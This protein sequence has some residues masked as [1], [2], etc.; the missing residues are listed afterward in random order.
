MDLIP[1]SRRSPRE[2]N[3]NLL[4]YSCWEIPWTEELDYSLHN[5]RVGQDWAM[6][7]YSW[8]PLLCLSH[9]DFLSF[10]LFYILFFYL[11]LFAF[12]FC[13]FRL[14]YSFEFVV[15]LVF[16]LSSDARKDRRQEDRR[17]GRQRTR[18]LNSITASMDMSWANSGRWWKTESLA[19]CSPW[20]RKELDM[21]ERLNNN[22]SSNHSSG[23]AQG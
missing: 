13:L 18:W 17:R 3:D 8:S 1:G 12:F 16:I 22:N 15:C 20:G 23:L 19:C 5:H 9:S 6:R 11:F 21:T 10:F 7:A 4:Q 14:E 2:Q